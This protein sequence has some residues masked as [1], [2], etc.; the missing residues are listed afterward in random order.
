MM[1]KCKQ[2]ESHNYYLWHSA[3]WANTKV[4]AYKCTISLIDNNIYRSALSSPIKGVIMLYRTSDAEEMKSIINK[5]RNM[6]D[7]NPR[8][9]YDHTVQ[10]E[11]ANM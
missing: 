1:M 2:H 6:Q 5:A 8:R 9:T 10:K 3:K 4:G 7:K 11:L